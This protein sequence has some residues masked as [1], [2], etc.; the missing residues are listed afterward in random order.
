MRC[1]QHTQQ[2]WRRLPY[3]FMTMVIL[4]GAIFGVPAG[5]GKATNVENLSLSPVPDFNKIAVFADPHYFDPE[6]GA[7]GAAFEEYLSND[8]KMLA[9]S[10]AIVKETIEQIKNTDAG[11]VLIPGDL[12]KDGEKTCHEKFAALLADLEDCGKKVYVIDG[13]HDIYNPGACRYVGDQAIP[14]DNLSPGEFKSIYSPFGY[15]E[16][17][18]EDPNSLSY[19][20]EP[21]NGL[22][23][24]AMDSAVYG[25]T[26]GAFSADTLNW[27]KDQISAAKLAGKTVLGMMHHN[28]IDHFSVQRQIFPE[29]VINDADQISSELA[30]AGM[31]VVFTGH[32]H[33]QDVVS[34]QVGNKY[35]YD[36]ENGSL[37][38]YPSPYRLVELTA[39]NKL[40]VTT[41]HIE[42]INYDTGGKPFP[43]YAKEFL[44][45][46]LQGLIPQ[47]LAGILIKQ[48]V[49]PQE[50]LQQ[51]EQ[52]ANTVV[53][54]PLTINDLLADAMVAHYQG[55]E[56][57][58]QQI[59]PVIQGMASS[60][61]S[62]VKMLGGALLS[63]WFDPAPEDNNLTIIIPGIELDVKPS[64]MPG[65]ALEIKG[66]YIG[67]E[68]SG[69][70]IAITVKNP[71]G[72]LSYVDETSTG[73][74]G[75]FGFYLTIPANAPTGLWTLD[76]AGGGCAANKT[77][78]VSEATGM[79]NVSP[80]S[81]KPGGVVT[82]SG[83]APQGNVPVGITI[84]DPN[85]SATFVDQTTAGAGGGYTFQ[86][87]VP[88]SAPT[89]TWTADVAGGGSAGRAAFTVASG[90][91]SGGG[92]ASPCKQPAAASY[93]PQTG[94]SNVALDAEV[95][96]IFDIAVSKASTNSLNGI[97][98]TD[99]YGNK[100]GNVAAVLSGTKLTLSH[101]AFEYNTKYTVTIPEA[102]LANNRLSRRQF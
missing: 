4:M 61:D 95:S 29:Y 14:V 54:P 89:G 68:V 81:V 99:E 58:N 100:V 52:M 13:N 9:E 101:D 30:Q 48:G 80:A 42:S 17:I 90:S 10:D 24:I 43:D 75:S 41:S 15:A 37:V 55:D 32:F 22:R 5:T 57:V 97:T 40:I 74:D 50:A 64:A 70:H 71:N 6:L 1:A 85:G 59:L 66:N 56:S 19:V 46:G 88:A 3:L 98:I 23:I 33:A 27:I 45:N 18:A 51:A 63:I 69:V 47:V 73:T 84:K 87:T 93:L 36:I 67:E 25:K 44:V 20:V 2:L 65:E 86:F 79:V 94:A 38:T 53:V 76:A 26:E 31:N 78:S 11:V 7:S 16:A 39:D 34:K 77:F 82:I 83:T 8:R 12:T 49:P 91:S 62:M 35:I 102:V 92:S 21:V 60:A 28:L 72:A 96:V